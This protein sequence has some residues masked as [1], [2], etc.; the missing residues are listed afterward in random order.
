MMAKIKNDFNKKI[1]KKTSDELIDY[2][3]FK[4]RGHVVNAAK[5]KGSKYN[6]QKEKR[7]CL[8][9]SEE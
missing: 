3:Q 5:G 2:M 4:R 7:N 1:L 8:L 6:R 9:T